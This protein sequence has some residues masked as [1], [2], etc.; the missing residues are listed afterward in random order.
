MWVIFNMK[1]RKK[2]AIE[3]E[4]LIWW[5]IAIVL[6]FIIIWIYIKLK[7]SGESGL[8]FIRNLFRFRS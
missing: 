5:I 4:T 1:K 2:G 7:G 6:L 3:L 8:D